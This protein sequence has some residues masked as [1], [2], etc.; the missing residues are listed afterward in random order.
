M[1]FRSQSQPEIK[2]KIQSTTSTNATLSKPRPVAAGPSDFYN[3]MIE[4]G[5]SAGMP[6]PHARQMASLSALESGWGKK[7]VASRGGHNYFG[8]TGV[9]PAGHT[10]GADGQKHKM[11]NSP[12][13][14]VSD[15]LKK[16]GMH[17]TD[18]PDETL[19]NLRSAG[20]NTVNPDWKS[21]IMDIHNRMNPKVETNPEE[22]LNEAKKR[23]PSW[24]LEGLSGPGTKKLLKFFDK[25]M[26]KNKSNKSEPENKVEK[27]EEKKL[28][29]DIHKKIKELPVKDIANSLGKPLYK[30]YRDIIKVAQG[31]KDNLKEEEKNTPSQLDLDVAKNTL[32]NM[33]LNQQKQSEEKAQKTIDDLKIKD[34]LN[35]D[36]EAN[37]KTNKY[38][39]EI[40][41]AHV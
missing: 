1:L 19:N 11:Y 41:R 37:P 4:A 29:P 13:E 12:E 7:G 35:K 14:A 15:H 20:Y 10:I 5:V 38:P 9:G 8:Q 36:Q 23:T 33:F 30:F 2:N 25:E 34:I 40:G 21:K 24:K 22:K 28:T 31:N 27:I 18:N 17:Y 26:E 16:W 39:S 3:Q 6:K 32:K